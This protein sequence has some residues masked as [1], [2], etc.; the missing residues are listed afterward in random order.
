MIA[1]I[2]SEQLREIA[3]CSQAFVDGIELGDER[4]RRGPT[5]CRPRPRARRAS[6]C[7]RR[8]PP[9]RH[10]RPGCASPPPPRASSPSAPVR[11]SSAAADVK[12]VCTVNCAA[13]RHASGPTRL[14]VARFEPAAGEQRRDARQPLQ[15]VERVGA[16]R[17]HGQ[18]ADRTECA[19][20]AH[21]GRRGVERDGAGRGNERRRASPRC[22]PSRARPCVRRVA[23]DCGPDRSR[24]AADAPRGAALLEFLEVAADGHLADA[25]RFRGGADGDE[26][27][28]A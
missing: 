8:G 20:E 14:P 19:R 22:A 7:R 12:N 5:R 16:V 25:K 1:G 27:V 13:A 28:R 6:S 10:R 26:A 15:R 9:A 18:V 23:N 3:V 17:E 11:G 24:S 2:P 4:C 21:D